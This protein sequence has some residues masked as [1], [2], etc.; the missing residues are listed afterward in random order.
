MVDWVFDR[1]SSNTPATGILN[2]LDAIG[3]KNKDLFRAGELLKSV[4]R[5]LNTL[6][7]DGAVAMVQELILVQPLDLDILPCA[8]TLPIRQALFQCRDSPKALV[9]SKDACELIGR[10]DLAAILVFYINGRIA[11]LDNFI[12]MIFL[13]AL[14]FNDLKLPN[15]GFLVTNG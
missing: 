14:L 2:I 13:L 15:F 3:K 5:V 10:S 6:Y 12:L 9:N 1:I 7:R 11:K 8:I 4:S